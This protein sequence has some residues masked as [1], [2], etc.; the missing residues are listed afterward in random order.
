MQRQLTPFYQPPYCQ[1]SRENNQPSMLPGYSGPHLVTSTPLL[2]FENH[3]P[4]KLL[5]RHYEESNMMIDIDLLQ[6]K[7]ASATTEMNPQSNA[8]NSEKRKWTFFQFCPN[9]KN[10][11]RRKRPE[12]NKPSV[13]TFVEDELSKLLAEQRPA[14]RP[15]RS[16]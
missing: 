8:S 5:Q 10:P 11:I 13:I 7:Y 2:F 12:P 6:E 4:T 1:M 16:Y 15:R 14:K 9:Q 3:T